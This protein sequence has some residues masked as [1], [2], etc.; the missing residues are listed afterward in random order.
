MQWILLEFM[1]FN[2]LTGASLS[3]YSRQSGKESLF[4]D[5]TVYYH[6]QGKWPYVKYSSAKRPKKTITRGSITL[7]ILNE[8]A[9]PLQWMFGIL[10]FCML[11][12]QYFPLPRISNVRG[13]FPPHTS[14][15]SIYDYKCLFPT[16]IGRTSMSNAS[17][18][19][20]RNTFN[21]NPKILVAQTFE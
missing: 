2:T 6:Q 11:E 1:R 14:T 15:A 21:T 16:A 8:L 7:R 9:C 13:L 10:N 17:S 4:E 3:L 20:T 18:L 12:Y 5:I 19:H